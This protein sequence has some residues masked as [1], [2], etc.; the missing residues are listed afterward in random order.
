M[1][2]YLSKLAERRLDNLLV[3]L[4][5]EW[6]DSTKAK[7]LSKV[8]EEFEALSSYPYSCKKTETFSDLYVCV[9]TKQTSALFRIL[10]HTEEIEIVTLFD[11]R[12][13]PAKLKKELEAHFGRR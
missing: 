10:E 4:E 8:R 9:I 13:D 2:V 1:R 11:N 7:F 5:N 3:Y 6:G 12:Q